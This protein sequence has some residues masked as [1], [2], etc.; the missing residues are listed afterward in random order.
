MGALVEEVLTRGVEE[1]IVKDELRKKLLSGK[2]LRLYLG[3]DPTG[4]SL[5]LGHA[6]VL[7]KLKEFVDLD[8]EVI[9]LIG[10][11]TAKIGDPTGKDAMRV[12]LTDKQIKENFKDYKKQA[13]KILDF[14]KV[15]IRYNST[16]L[17]KLRFEDILKLAGHFTVQQMLHRDMFDKRMKES[18]PINQT[19]FIYPLMQGYDSV[20]MDVDLEIGGNDQMFNMLAGRTL[21][22][23]Y[24]NR[25]KYIITTKL[26]LGTDGRKMSKTYDNAIYL[27][28]EPNDMFGKVMSIKDELIPDYLELATNFSEAEVA[29]V[30]KIANPRDQKAK[31]AAEI[32]KMYHGEALAQK[33][34]EEFNTIFKSGGLPTDIPVFETPR[35]NYPILDLLCDTKLAESKNDAKRVIE[36]N[37]VTIRNKE[38]ETII[39]NWKEEIKVEN[40]MIVK[41]GKRKFIKIKIK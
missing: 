34:E 38:Q 36:G 29:E 40:G 39:K 19:E 23:A 3:V 25:D 27:N 12:P 18:A 31:L 24:N 6:V 14:W 13:S 20:V 35:V 2:K 30:K 41:F 21:Q 7:R 8:H 10:D 9:L 33:A 11:F 15:K 5:H 17:S 1:V 4:F 32:V 22:K 28:D 16:W 26:L 37:G